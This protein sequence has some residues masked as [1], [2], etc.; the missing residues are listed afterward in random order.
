MGGFSLGRG[1]KAAGVA[2]AAGVV[3]GSAALV[4]AAPATA[5]PVP[6]KPAVVA[7]KVVPAPA[8][9]VAPKTLELNFRDADIDQVLRVYSLASGLTV[10]K[11]P[12][13]KGTVTIIS[14]GKLSLDQA[15]DV[16]SS[17]LSV[18]GY[19]LRRSE[20]VLTVIPVSKASEPGVLAGQKAGGADKTDRIVT[21]VIALKRSNALELQRELAPMV[22]ENASLMASAQTN[23]LVVT[24]F[25]SKVQQLVSVVDE[26]EK[27]GSST[28]RQA[29]GAG[30]GKAAKKA[31]AALAEVIYVRYASAADLAK[32][33]TTLFASNAKGDAQGG[34][35]A[36]QASL[37]SQLPFEQRLTGGGAGQAQGSAAGQAPT[38]V[39]PGGNASDQSG[40]AALLVLLGQSMAQAT[41]ASSAIATRI[42]AD[43]YS[44]SLIVS[45][46]AET[47]ATIKA[48]VASVDQGGAA[49][50]TSVYRVRYGRA[51]DLANTVLNLFG[52]NQSYQ[53]TVQ[54]A[55]LQGTTAATQA[56]ASVTTGTG[57]VAARP[58]AA[59]AGNATG[60][61]N[62]NRQQTNNARNNA[63][64]N[65]SNQ[66]I[67]QLM[68]AF[69][70]QGGSAAGSSGTRS[71][72]RINSDFKVVP[73]EAN[74][75]IVL[76]GP[77][78]ILDEIR[79][80]LVQ[81]DVAPPQV[82]IEA[83][84]AEVSLD[85]GDKMGISWDSIVKSPGIS[86][87]ATSW[88]GDPIG[89]V[90]Y[91]VIAGGI[92]AILETIKT[93]SRFRVLSTPSVMTVNN[94]Q[95]NMYVGKQIPY[96]SATTKDVNGNT[97]STYAYRDVGVTLQVFPRITESG[98]MSLDIY[99]DSSEVVA[100]STANVPAFSSRNA[101]TSVMVKH[102]ET[103]VIGGII[104]EDKTEQVRKVPFLGD[105]PYIG[106]LFR[107]KE[108]VSS[109]T[110]LVIF[111][112]PQIVRGP[113]DAVAISGDVKDG[114]SDYM[115]ETVIQARPVPALQQSGIEG[116]LEETQ[117]AE[118]KA[119][120]D[121]AAAEAAR[122]AAQAARAANSRPAA[123]QPAPAPAA[124]A[125]VAPA[126]TVTPDAA[127]VAPTVPAGQRQRPPR[128]P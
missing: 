87:S 99:Q 42:V 22:S 83:V 80:L 128:T 118:A 86:G 67:K 45:G 72:P 117:D 78:E 98:Y 75:A 82:H 57:P 18:R 27:G 123:T 66:N 91:Q 79:D 47:I 35:Q 3:L 34:G 81:L 63:G 19:V 110:E 7:T 24:D 61:T 103:V 11:D 74:N 113:A 122:A 40:G 105:I 114:L 112:T 21:Q 101:R 37:A 30:G 115:Q 46:S 100:T 90:K 124:D 76:S 84:I 9:K 60:N 104:R 70:G 41:A 13:V 2:F 48:L 5:K 107:R 15:F 120:A 49:S 58:Q 16:L 109:K 102:G 92:A 25:V 29:A 36:G 53:A 89:G 106:A 111:I 32:S 1:L 126:A 116:K 20:R 44:N 125:A 55:L 73:N 56:R 121:A 38:Q 96:V 50:I 14:S 77:K 71:R 33:L 12:A 23:T 10:V 39:A 93:D 59:A 85:Q 69:A 26:L 6:P 65:A 95:A 68:S 64:G 119:L 8:K 62:N 52:V 94:S 17:M 28:D 108:Q 4:Q 31:D 51:V 88:G 54:S 97:Q 43:T 127:V